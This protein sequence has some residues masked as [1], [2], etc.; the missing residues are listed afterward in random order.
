MANYNWELIKERNGCVKVELPDLKVGDVILFDKDA[1]DAQGNV[2]TDIYRWPGS[3]DIYVQHCPEVTPV[4][5]EGMFK[6]GKINF[7]HKYKK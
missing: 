7:R 2:V 1:D 4:C 3:D 6:Y 5:N